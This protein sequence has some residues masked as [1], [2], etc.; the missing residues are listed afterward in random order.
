[1]PG[2]AFAA[3]AGSSA[4]GGIASFIPLIIIFLICY[5]LYK[6]SKKHSK[7]EGAYDIKNTATVLSDSQ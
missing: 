3:E 4:S 5:F 7:K 2:I 6:K 1:M